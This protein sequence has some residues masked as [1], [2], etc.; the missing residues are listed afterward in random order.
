MQPINTA[1][2][3]TRVLSIDLL[4]GLVMIIMALDHIRDYFHADAFNFDPLDLEKTTPVLFFTRWITHF[5]APVFMFLAGT[6][7]FLVG[8]RKGR[9]SLAR[10][11]L[12]RG[13][14]LVVMEMTVFN[15]GW[16]FN[17]HFPSFDF[18]VIWA[19]GMCMI[20][21]AGLIYLPK[22]LI[23]AI[24]II[25][26][27]GHNLLDGVNI[28]G[29]GLKAFGWALL[30]RPGLFFFGGKGFFVGYPL[31]PWLGIMVLGYSLGSLYGSGFDAA[32]RKKWLLYLGSG[33]ILLFIVLRYSNEYG[34]ANL[35]S[36]QSS[37]LFSV[38]SFIDTVKYPPSLLYTCMT[39][40][41]ALIFLAFT[42]WSGRYPF[43]AGCRC[44]ITS[45]TFISFTCWQWPP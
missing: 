8:E 17:P 5:C 30:H 22:K 14:F 23:L 39:L 3:R 4:R 6:S 26:V 11:L 40:G 2:S 13:L 34:D 16:F 45:F 24:G 44:S 20:T 9:K 38:L 43:T 32:R 10:F 15:F 1:A 28:P 35:W 33:T 12:T 41:P 27:L 19:L 42:G 7:A 25:I 29:E 18:I 36:R 31:L 21:L 37:A